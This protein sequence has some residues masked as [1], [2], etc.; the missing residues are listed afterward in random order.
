MR[1]QFI[2]AGAV[3]AVIVGAGQA[4]AQNCGGTN[5]SM[6]ALNIENKVAGKYTCVGAYPHAQWNELLSG[7]PTSGN[8]IDYKL[9]ATDPIDPTKQVGTYTVTGS[10]VGVLNYTYGATTYSY[11]IQKTSLA[12]PFSTLFCPVGPGYSGVVNVQVNHC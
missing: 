11:Q 5:K 6:T 10:T 2:M 9:G 4:V 8:V 12:A 3:L 1:K 7:S